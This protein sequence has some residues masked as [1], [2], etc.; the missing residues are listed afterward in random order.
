MNHRER[1]EIGD[2]EILF[3]P[4]YDA[5]KCGLCPFRLIEW[6][7]DCDH[8]VEPEPAKLA[9]LFGPATTVFDWSKRLVCSRGRSHDADMVVVTG[10][11][12]NECWRGETCTSMTC[13][14]RRSELQVTCK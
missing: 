10:T 3:P 11:E 13:F 12:R 4:T 14:A 6:C 1:G 7:R 8:Q 9:R 5:R 2:G